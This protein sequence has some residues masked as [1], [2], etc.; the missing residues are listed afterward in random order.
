[1]S[2]NNNN[3]MF[4]RVCKRAKV[5]ALSMNNL[6]HSFASQHLAAR[7]V[8]LQVSYM[9]GHSTPAVTLSIYSHWCEREKSTAQTVL[10]N[11][12]FGA[13]EGEGEQHNSVA[14]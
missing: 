13:D 11:R 6:R 3:D 4:K 1:M 7:T 8:P 14:D 12:I 9:M 5:R 2:G 10:A